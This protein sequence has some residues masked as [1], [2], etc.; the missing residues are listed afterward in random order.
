MAGSRQESYT[1]NNYMEILGILLVIP[2]LCIGII[3][4]RVTNYRYNTYIQ[5]RNYQYNTYNFHITILQCRPN[6]FKHLP[7]P[8]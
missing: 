6:P 7:A 8:I 5:H 1:V 3:P 2:M 4:I